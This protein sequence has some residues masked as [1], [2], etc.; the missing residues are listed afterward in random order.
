MLAVGAGWYR[1]AALTDPGA[2]AVRVKRQGAIELRGNALDQVMVVVTVAASDDAA[3]QTE[4]EVIRAVVQ[5]GDLQQAAITVHV[6]E[7]TLGQDYRQTIGIMAQLRA[8][9]GIK[10]WLPRQQVAAGQG[11]QAIVEQLSAAG[12]G[13]RRQ[14]GQ[15][16]AAA[17]GSGQPWS[18]SQRLSVHWPPG[19]GTAAAGAG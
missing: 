4:L 13:Q 15:Q 14:G 18:G 9:L 16:Q 2:A 8:R 11:L 3:D 17:Q 19:A 12:S 1:P 5:R 7:V 6:L 10:H